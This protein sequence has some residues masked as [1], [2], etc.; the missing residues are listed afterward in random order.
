[1]C[2]KIE[3]MFPKASAIPMQ[4]TYLHLIIRIYIKM[5]DKV[6]I[7]ANVQE[8]KERGGGIISILAQTA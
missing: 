6:A 4:T 2:G 1:L 3:K 7:Q 5:F 8:K